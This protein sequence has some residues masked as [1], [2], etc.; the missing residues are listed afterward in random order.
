MLFIFAVVVA[1]DITVNF[2]LELYI[3]PVGG[4][5]FMQGREIFKP[6]F[7]LSRP[8]KRSKTKSRL[9]IKE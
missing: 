6:I 5:F 4:F 2:L 8:P 9:F 3:F 7:N 1:I